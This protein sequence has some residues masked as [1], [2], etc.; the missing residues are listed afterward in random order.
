MVTRVIRLV[1]ENASRWC[2]FDGSWSNYSNYS[3]CRDVREPAIDGGVEVI[4][5]TIYFVGYSISLLTLIIAVS[6]FLYCK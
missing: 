6:I 5:T 2:S 3:L 1:T 4:S